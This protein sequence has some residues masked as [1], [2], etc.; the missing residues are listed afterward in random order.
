MISVPGRAGITFFED[1]AIELSGSLSHS[2]AASGAAIMTELIPFKYRAFL[3]YSH[4]DT[5]WVKRLHRRLEGFRIDKD[6]T[7]R[8]TPQGL[9]PKTLRP[10]FR[11][12]DDFIAGHTL[13]DQTVA[14]LD[15]SAALIVLCSP[16]SARS[17]YVNEEVRLFKSRHPERPV[18]PVIIDGAPDDP[19]R[20]CFAP[21]LRFAVSGDGTVTD[22]PDN[23]LAA[24]V[25]ESG[26]G[27]DLAV[28]KVVARLLDLS[29]DDVYRR[30][31]RA[32]RRSARVRDGV[33]VALALL[34]VAAAGS[35]AYA[36]QQLKTN[37]AFLEATLRRATGIVNT[38]VAQAEKYN[39][40]RAATLE[41]LKTAE[42]LF[43]DMGRLGRPTPALQR[44]KA[45]MLIQFARN[46]E[47]LGNS[48]KQKD[49]ADEAQRIM[50]SL[51][52][53]G[54]PIALHDL[55]VAQDEKGKALL[56]RGD[57]AGA[58]AAFNAALLAE[59]RAAETSPNNDAL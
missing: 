38:A 41:V 52:E 57:L 50:A 11:D 37:E 30:A 10:I 28:A 15:A 13:N 51:A 14:A 33:I 32:R 4:A 45:W 40:P 1:A 36:W 6:L 42:G 34:T 22:T 55:A 2:C 23:E 3:S 44:Q 35:A 20:E 58:E 54:D 59:A 21:A 31:E 18:I 16:A 7:G 39:V 25:R 46:Y 29:T 27:F 5:A 19:E 26:D 53:A 9:I 8:E 48:A 43:D 24:D 12:R 17:H 49:H 47:L 56:S